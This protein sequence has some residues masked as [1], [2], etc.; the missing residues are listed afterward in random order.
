MYIGGY[1]EVEEKAP[2]YYGVKEITYDGTIDVNG[3]ID[4]FNLS[5]GN[6]IPYSN[7]RVRS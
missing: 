1:K 5:N 7:L 6:E 4:K 3:V 2:C